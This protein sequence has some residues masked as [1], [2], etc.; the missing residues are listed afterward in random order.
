MDINLP[1][2]SGIECTRRWYSDPVSWTGRLTSSLCNFGSAD[3]DTIVIAE[4]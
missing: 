1:D 4:G 2:L 3:D